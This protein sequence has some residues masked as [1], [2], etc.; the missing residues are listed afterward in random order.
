M[1]LR[2]DSEGRW[3]VDLCVRR[4]RLHRR[5]PA[6]TSASDAKRIEAELTAALG[7]ARAPTVPGDPPLT[8]I[9][10]AYTEHY[11]PSGVR[12]PDTA[13]HHAVRIGRWCELYRAS[14]AR[15][16]AAHII[17]DLRPHY[18]PATINRSLGALK[19]ALRLAWER[20]LLVED[21]GARIKRLP[22]NNVRDVYLTPAQVARLAKHAS[23][24]VR[25]AIWVALLTG[26]RRGEICKIEKEDIGRDAILLRAGNT[27][28]L[29]TR[30]VP[31]FPALRP[32]LKHLPLKVSAEGIK[33]GFQR[34]R[35]AAGMEHVNFHD[36]RHSC[37]SI[38]VGLGVDLYTVSKILGHS[39]V[40]TTERYAHLQMKAQRAALG[41]LGRAV[42]ARRR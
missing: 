6:G 11:L 38:L 40:K 26:A 41:K 15:E 18:E 17:A 21:Y 16:C 2:K 31:I 12:S 28:T 1:P 39:T 22:E 10:A 19:R 27:K 30:S 32:W 23:A 7:A 24:N 33:T 25:A 34:A 9:M 14:Q 35:T 5:L 42:A 13:K 37:A 8:E 36:F 20:G 29:K 3:H 4:R